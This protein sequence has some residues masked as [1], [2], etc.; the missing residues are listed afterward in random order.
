MRRIRASLTS[1]VVIL[2]RQAGAVSVADDIAVEL[3]AVAL[4]DAVT[5]DLLD[6]LRGKST[7][8]LE[9]TWGRGPT[10]GVS[11]AAT[12]EITLDNRTS[13]E[14]LARVFDVKQAQV[15][16]AA[17]DDWAKGAID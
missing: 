10:V 11:T 4:V 7:P 14:Y 13:R 8:D 12:A 9:P 5:G 17:T 2:R 3:D 15:V 16:P 1:T 6:A